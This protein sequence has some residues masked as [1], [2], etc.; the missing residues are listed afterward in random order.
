M[1]AVQR[2]VVSNS[3]ITGC[4]LLNHVS[5]TRALS[6]QL[7]PCTHYSSAGRDSSSVKIVGGSK[8]C[9]E[10]HSHSGSGL[11]LLGWRQQR[12]CRD[13]CEVQHPL[14]VPLPRCNDPHTAQTAG[15][16]VQQLHT[17]ASLLQWHQA[18][19][20]LLLPDGRYHGHCRQGLVL[21][22]MEAKTRGLY[23]CLSQPS[24]AAGA[25]IACEQEFRNS[26][27]AAPGG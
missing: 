25:C 2:N 12:L 3:Q 20:H 26:L 1:A 9:T 10:L 14:Q 7:A 18:T 22:S 4:V 19:L 23:A 13:V 6:T 5:L 15:H 21:S 11:R 24:R 16:Q 27:Q 8:P 17:H